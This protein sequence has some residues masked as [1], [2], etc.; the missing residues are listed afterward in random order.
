MSQPGDIGC[1][2]QRSHIFSSL[3]TGANNVLLRQRTLGGREIESTL[4]RHVTNVLI[5]V[6]ITLQRIRR[7]G[8]Y[9]QIFRTGSHTATQL[10]HQ[11]LVRCRSNI[12]TDL[13]PSN[14]KGKNRTTDTLFQQCFHT[15]L[16]GFWIFSIVQGPSWVGVFFLHLR[17]ETDSFWNVVFS[18]F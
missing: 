5:E 11:P 16:L 13:L 12:F 2:K 10:Q 18:I 17:A 3:W 9:L 6:F 8:I 14:D 1:R 15:E 7:R 4:V